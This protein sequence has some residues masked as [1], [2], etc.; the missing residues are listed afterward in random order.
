MKDRDKEYV[1]LQNKINRLSGRIANGGKIDIDRYGAL[2][3]EL[4]KFEI[5]KKC[6]GAIIGSKAKWA[7]ESD[8]CTIY[9]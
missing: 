5:E 2:K 9:F 3:S 6:R 8:K 1:A 4:S 7:N